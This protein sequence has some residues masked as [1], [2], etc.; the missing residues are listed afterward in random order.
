MEA[1]PFTD[2]QQM[3]EE[4]TL[5]AV[6]GSRFDDYEQ[7]TVLASS[8]SQTWNFS[9]SSGWML[10]VFDRKKALFYLIPLNNAFKISLTIRENE[11]EKLLEDAELAGL[12]EKI[13]AAKKYPEGYALQ[14]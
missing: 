8:Y 14:F 5:R 10:K 12:R 9:K 6:L 3:P 11:R 13:S 7:L 1:R 2:K 4:T